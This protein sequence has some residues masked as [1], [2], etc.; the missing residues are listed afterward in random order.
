MWILIAALITSTA[1]GADVTAKKL[2][3]ATLVGTLTSWQDGQVVLSTPGGPQRAAEADLLFLERSTPANSN[4]DDDI[5]KPIVELIDGTVVPLT[6]FSITGSQATVVPRYD[7]DSAPAKSQP[8]PVEVKKVKSVRL[9]PMSAAIEKQWEDVRISATSAD[10]TTPSDLLVVLKHG[11]QTLD[12]LEGVIGQ[13]TERDVEFT[14]DGDIVHVGRDKVAGLVFYRANASSDEV[15]RCVLSG[16]GDLRIRT[17][18]NIRLVGDDLQLTTLTGV[19]LRWPWAEITSADFSAGKL[20]FLS[21]L[22]PVSQSWQPLIALPAAATHASALGQPRID[23]A[24]VGGSLTLWYPDGEQSSAS[25]HA[26]SFSKGLALRSKTEIVYRLPRGFSR[27]SAV[28][29]IEPASRSTGDVVLNILGDD[30]SLLERAVTGGDPPLPIDL[31][32]D[33]VKQLKIIV[34]YGKNLDT[35]DWL[36]L[37]NARIVK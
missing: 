36:N 14:H 2:D 19:N 5:R 27:F 10:S 23:R 6:N 26:K 31:N 9:Q 32:V 29:G 12:Y 8:V 1:A 18:N 21:D 37:C 16:A 11:G 24:S 33:G 28:A 35:G 7:A 15:P 30:H 22:T 25:G 13:V 20:V 3:G 4:T 17:A 34:D